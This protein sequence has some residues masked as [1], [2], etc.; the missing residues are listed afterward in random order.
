MRDF[1]THFERVLE[2]QWKALKALPGAVCDT[3]A[4]LLRGRR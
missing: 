2:L 4:L 3:W 1:Q